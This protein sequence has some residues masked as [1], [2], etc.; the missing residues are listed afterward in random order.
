VKISPEIQDS[1]EIRF[2]STARDLNRR[3]ERIISLGLGEPGFAT[4]APIIDAAAQAMRDGHTRYSNPF[5]LPELCERI[6][7]KLKDENGI[8]AK[9]SDIIVTPGSKMALSLALG[10]I[11]SP[12]DQA[13][14]VTPCYP[15]Y[16]PQIKISEADCV[17]RAIDLRRQDF[18]LDLD[19]IAAAL[20]PAT[21]ALIIN[22]PHN[23]TGAMIG[24][25]EIEAL[26]DILSASQCILISDEIYE[27]LNFSGAP[28]ISPASHDKLAQRTITI[29]GFSKAY[30]MTG[31]RIGYLHVPDRDLLR[32]ISRLHQHLNTNTAAFIQKAA[33]AALDLPPE[34]VAGY[35][36][37][38]AAN[39]RALRDALAGNPTV[40]VRPS[41]GG[42]FAFVN[43]AASGQTSDAF[44]TGLLERHRVAVTPGI[45][46]G[47]AW[48]D[49]IRVSLA[50]SR[51][52]VAAG[53]ARLA[54]FAAQLSHG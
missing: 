27:R 36:A 1:L 25:D 33:L 14:Y 32:V 9:A 6:A 46:F 3:G 18:R 22:S 53:V 30:S 4:P 47:A 31:W 37:T 19:A 43:I 8:D 13:I 41:K 34:I 5:G 12:G 7:S 51:E 16:L 48:D 29:N 49:H 21:K 2:R 44:A 10:A 50:S 38:L 17:A 39:D 35:V 42:L 23:P 15:S 11:L 52:E 28:H 20:T 26:A 45:L 54:D 40:S 24:R